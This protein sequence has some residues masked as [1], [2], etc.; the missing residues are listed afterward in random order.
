MSENK[1]DRLYSKKLFEL[2]LNYPIKTSYYINSEND[3]SSSSSSNIKKYLLKNICFDINKK[4]S[5]SKLPK[6]N[7]KFEG[8]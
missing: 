2:W 1:N 8:D 4:P 6:I 3:N 7:L 5:E